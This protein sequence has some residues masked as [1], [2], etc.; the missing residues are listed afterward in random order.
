M[1]MRKNINC[2]PHMYR[3]IELG[4]ILLVVMNWKFSYKDDIIIIIIII[5]I[6]QRINYMIGRK[7]LQPYLIIFRNQF[8][9]SYCNYN[10][11]LFTKTNNIWFLNKTKM[12]FIFS[13]SIHI[14]IHYKF[15]FQT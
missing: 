9:S 7:T 1:H 11:I 5:I 13:H 14:K 3:I 6:M 8:P 15:I 10:P 12:Y 2:N 4:F